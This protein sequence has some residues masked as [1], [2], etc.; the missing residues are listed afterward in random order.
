MADKLGILKNIIGDE[1][2][3]KVLD[4]VGKKEGEAEIAGLVNKEAKDAETEKGVMGKMHAQMDTAAEEKVEIDPKTGKPVKPKD[5]AEKKEA[6]EEPDEALVAIFTKVVSD[7]NEPLMTRLSALEASQAQAKK[8]FDE[9]IGKRF[10]A[11]EASIKEAKDGVTE[12]LGDMPKGV[13]RASEAA[14]TA[15]EKAQALGEKAGPAPDPD[16]YDFFADFLMA[17]PK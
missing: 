4:A 11:I 7:A 13:K 5:T 16:R 10:G 3:N 2:Y 8:E 14:R 12:L 6:D 9:E 15:T 17:H 1:L